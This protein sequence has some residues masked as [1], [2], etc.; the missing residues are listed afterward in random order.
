MTMNRRAFSQKFG[1]AVVLSLFGLNGVSFAEKKPEKFSYPRN[2]KN[3]EPSLSDAKSSM[4]VLV[5]DTQ[6]YSNDSVF[7]SV[8]DMVYAWIA[9]STQNL[10]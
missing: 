7:H 10:T 1:F 2:D 5:G 6:R 4:L 3:I 9:R 8:C